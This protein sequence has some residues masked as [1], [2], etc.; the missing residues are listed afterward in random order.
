[1]YKISLKINHEIVFD[2]VDML[3]A[4]FETVSCFE[5]MSS[6]AS[7]IVDENEFPVA[8]LFDI[9]IIVLDQTQFHLVE[10]LLN[11][12]RIPFQNISIE[13]IQNQDWLEVCY[14]N[15]EPL[16]VGSFFIYSSYAPEAVPHGSIGIMIDA[17]T[18]FG[19]GEH[20]TTR[21][22]LMAIEEALNEKSI[23]S[24]LDM[25]CGS[26]ILGLSCGLF[27]QDLNITGV[28]I[29]EKA[30]DVANQNAILNHVHNF[31]ARHSIGFSNIDHTEKYDLIVAN[32]L[33]RPL[34]EMSKKIFHHLNHNGRIILSGL[35]KR[36]EETVLTTY[37]SNG[38]NYIHS[39]EI[40]EWVACVLE[41]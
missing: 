2:V 14:K 6:P 27:K 3:D 26:G 28:D 33:A 31:K 15:F 11:E 5:D 24:V 25:G 13:E 17:A 1:M 34:I 10:F 8:S 30:V 16:E 9:E 22:C 19:S 29:D 37:I 4:Y 21:A 23:H 36:Q 41:K 20:Q 38:F 32:I 12:A 39:F 35:L 7:N 18:A 40:D